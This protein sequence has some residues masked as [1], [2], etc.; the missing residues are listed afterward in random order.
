MEHGVN[1]PSHYNV[2]PSGKDG[3][4]YEVIKIIEFLGWGYAFCMGNALKYALRAPYK[5]EFVKDVQKA[6]WYLRRAVENRR[7]QLTKEKAM[8]AWG[9]DKR[10]ELYSVIRL[11]LDGEPEVAY[12]EL[13]HVVINL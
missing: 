9:I 3:S 5:G 2:G 8:E 11:I 7:E 1:H 4:E 10:Y 12:A 13:Q 6:Q